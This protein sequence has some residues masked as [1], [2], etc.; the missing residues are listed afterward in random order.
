MRLVV[1]LK[2]VLVM[3]EAEQDDRLV[4]DGIDLVFRFLEQESRGQP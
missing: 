1:P 3:Q 4:Q 2:H